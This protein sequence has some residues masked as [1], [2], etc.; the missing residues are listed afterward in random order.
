M[1]IESMVM[2]ALYI[3]IPLFVLIYVGFIV[4]GK[5][6]EIRGKKPAV[7]PEQKPEQKPEEKKEEVK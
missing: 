3:G 7:K 6:Q 5:V 1:T 2:Q 4:W